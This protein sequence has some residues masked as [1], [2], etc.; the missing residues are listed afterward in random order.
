MF[1]HVLAAVGTQPDF[2]AFLGS[3]WAQCAGHVSGFQVYLGHIRDVSG[4][5][6]GRNLISKHFSTVFGTWYAGHVPDV[7]G[8][9]PD[10]QAFLGSF[11]D[12]MYRPCLG[13]DRDTGRFLGPSEHDV[14]TMQCSG[15]FPTTLGMQVDFQPNEGSTVYKPCQ[16]R[17]HVSKRSGQSLGHGVQAI[18]GTSQG[19]GHVQ[20]ASE[21]RQG[22]SLIFRHLRIVFGHDVQA[23]TGMRPDRGSFWEAVCSHVQDMSGPW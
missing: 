10:V 6:Q 17:K 8:T 16:G 15:C 5:R 2:Q 19:H 23:M 14:Q 12:R 1:L 11:W 22:W 3:L 7:A 18:F 21:P 13:H 9:Q 4:P 20:D